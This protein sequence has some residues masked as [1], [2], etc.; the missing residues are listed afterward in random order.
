MDVSRKKEKKARVWSETEL[1][2]LA[3]V[4]ADEKTDF[5]V[6]LDTLALKKSAN[7]EVFE[8]VKQAFEQS[9][10]SEEFIEEFAREKG[11]SK[12]KQ[13]DAFS[14]NLVVL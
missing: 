6:K 2:F 13:W 4:L 10:S 12:S 9:L 5:A 7:N 1:K 11:I 3:I 8:Q 14:T